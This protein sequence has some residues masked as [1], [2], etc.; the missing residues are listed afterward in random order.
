MNSSKTL[1]SAQRDALLDTLQLRFGA[2]PKR[3][4]GI[5]WSAVQTRLEQHPEK[6]WS[7]SEM[8]ATGGEPDVIGRDSKTGEYLFCDCSPESPNG[9]RSAC[10]DRAALESRKEHKPKT[11]AME[12]AL[13]ME[14]E[15][16]TEEQYRN[17]Q[18]L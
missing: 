15:M 11:S 13:A 16:L 4:D 14:I 3:H 17:L 5:Q 18:K 10:Y 9:R 2:H 12:M 1:T 6:L 7:L 8:E